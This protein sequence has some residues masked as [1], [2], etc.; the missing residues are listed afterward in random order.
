MR[1][2]APVFRVADPGVLGCGLL[3][4]IL[5]ARLASADH[6]RGARLVMTAAGSFT[7]ESGK[8]IRVGT[9]G[10][11]GKGWRK[12]FYPPELPEEEWL[13][14]YARHFDVVELTATF[15]RL[16]DDR[17]VATWAGMVPE[18]FR[19]LVRAP[20]RICHR[21]RL[22]GCEAD[23]A[24]FLE[25]IRGLGEKLAA[26]VW[27]LPP[28]FKCDPARLE[29]FLPLLPDDMVHVMEFRH[30][31]WHRAGVRELL[32]AH[33][34]SMSFHDHGGRR[35]PWW[36]TGPAVVFRLNG[37]QAQKRCYG[38]AGLTPFVEAVEQAREETD[39]PVFVIFGDDAEGC[40]VRDA[41]ILQHLLGQPPALPAMVEKAQEAHTP[42]AIAIAGMD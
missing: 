10:W 21:R 22:A 20:R 38:L 8:D 32:A 31:S 17:Q 40:A 11:A 26:V 24:A 27:E 13:R 2:N 12:A 14:H 37:M 35:T 16:P 6:R 28:T 18:D 5:F 4:H 3:W 34:V 30:A 23:V 41:S 29:A 39:G 25:C 36:I 42:V 7:D 15:Y 9:S 33:G 19:F 1:R